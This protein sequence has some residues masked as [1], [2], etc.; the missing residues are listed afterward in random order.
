MYVPYVRYYFYF[1][2]VN[3]RADKQTR[4]TSMMIGTEFAM[5]N[6]KTNKQ[7]NI[8]SSSHKLS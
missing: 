4:Q 1:L 6:A 2:V 8:L 7:E 3:P 5:G